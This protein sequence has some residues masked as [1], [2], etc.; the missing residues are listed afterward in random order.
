MVLK[1]KEPEVFGNDTK[2]HSCAHCTTLLS[3]AEVQAKKK[4]R[5]LQMYADENRWHSNPLLL[6]QRE[7]VCPPNL[8][9]DIPY[10]LLTVTS[11]LNSKTPLKNLAMTQC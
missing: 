4:K 5:T 3:E 9:N 6:L 2:G 1:N 11:N 10:I 7:I 8:W